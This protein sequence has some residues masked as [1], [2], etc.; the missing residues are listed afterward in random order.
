MPGFL[1]GRRHQAISG[2]VRL[3]SI[4]IWSKSP[5]VLTSKPYLERLDNPTL[6]TKKIM[7]GIFINMNRTVC[8]RTLRRGPFRGAYA[9][10]VRFDEAPDEGAL[11]VLLDQ[12]V[13]D[14]NIAGGEI[15]IADRFRPASRCRWR[16]N[17]AAATRR[18]KA[19]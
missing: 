11:A 8:R 12:L 3:S 5:A 14:T 17:C 4:S 10:T 16:K 19:R 2:I 9:V 13:A 1:Y 18:S 15:W 6:M 7:S